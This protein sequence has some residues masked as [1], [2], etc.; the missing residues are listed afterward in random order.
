MDNSL[1]SQSLLTL[2]ISLVLILGISSITFCQSSQGDG[3]SAD[4]TCIRM[5]L[6]VLSLFFVVIQLFLSHYMGD[7]DIYRARFLKF[8]AKYVLPNKNESELRGKINGINPETEKYD[9]LLRDF[10]LFRVSLLHAGFIDVTVHVCF[11][12]SIFV[13]SVLASQL[14]ELQIANS[15]IKWA[16]MGIIILVGL[17]LVV[18]QYAFVGQGNAF[19]RR[20]N[21]L[22]Q[23]GFYESCRAKVHLRWKNEL[24]ENRIAGVLYELT[25]LR[26]R[27]TIEKYMFRFIIIALQIVSVSGY[28]LHNL[29]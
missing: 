11:F 13:L 16:T 19:M 5:F 9:K 15:P 1:R 2:I 24:C 25:K 12:A 7:H 4:A 28:P 21:E 20:I 29:W 26:K 10:L 8:R 22:E 14:H 3:G 6:I 23:L 27:R 17:F 18:Q